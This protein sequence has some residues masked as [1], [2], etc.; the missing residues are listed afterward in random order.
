M[1]KA[2]PV[3][4]MAVTVKETISRSL[5][6]AT[7]CRVEDPDAA[8]KTLSEIRATYPDATHHCYAFVAGPPHDGRVAGMG[9]DGEPKGT[10]GGPMFQVLSHSGI[11]EILVVVTRYYG[12]TKLGTGGLVKAYSNMTR[13]VTKAL[14]TR[15]LQPEKRVWLRCG[16]DLAALARRI[17]AG[18]KGRIVG[19]TY[20]ADVV[21]EA[22][23]PFTA[24]KGFITAVEDRSRG[25]IFVRSDEK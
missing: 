8:R 21:L 14:E 22:M 18:E 15:M 9:D 19:E 25:G 1:E 3:P 24:A 2:Y 4:A 20:G 7:A 13:M 23:I 11:G 5:F 16:Y 12:G 17:I 6:I 10:A